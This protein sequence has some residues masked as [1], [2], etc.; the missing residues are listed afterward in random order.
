METFNQQPD[1]MLW[2]IARRRAEFKKRLIIYL[3]VN[4]IVWGAWIISSIISRHFG[5]IWPVF[6]TLGWGIGLTLNYINTYTGFKDS[7]VQKEYQKLKEQSN[8]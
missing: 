6:I 5:F 7:M 8:K 2:R 3:I 4:I 1:E